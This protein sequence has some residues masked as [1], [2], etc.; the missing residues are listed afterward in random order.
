MRMVFERGTVGFRLLTLSAGMVALTG[1]TTSCGGDGEAS[2]GGGTE[3]VVGA[4]TPLS[5]DYAAVSA[6]VKA[7]EAAFKE[8]NANGGIDGVKVKFIM[9]DDQYNPANTPSATRDLVESEGAVMM[10]DSQGAVP[11]ASVKDYLES[12]QIPTVVNAGD[13]TLDGEFHYLVISDYQK[14]GAELVRYASEDLGAKSIAVTYSDDALGNPV[15]EG[16]EAELSN[17][18]LDSAATIKFDP[19]A[20]SMS[21]QAAQLKESGADFVVLPGTA[22]TVAKLINSAEQI[23]YT[24]DWGLMFA[25]QSPV[26]D[27]LTK[28][29]VDG[30]AH[31]VTPFIDPASDAGAEYRETL[32]E[33]APDIEPNDGPTIAG[34]TIAKVCIAA[35]EKAVEAANG[36]V[37]TSEQIQDALSS[38]TLDD[39]FIQGIDW[40]GDTHQ[41][42]SSGQVLKL[43]GGEF[44][45]QTDFAPFPEVG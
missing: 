38:L 17:L 24:P 30:R 42:S 33:Y 9:R 43:E 3:I 35:L 23:G 31:F 14:F 8:L 21:A 13:P 4:T 2:S 12:R 39:E 36:E 1:L 11:Q 37:P 26:L 10:C 27:E 32:E 22:P 40:S 6:G 19:A 5:G 16:A 45:P 41:G 44:V 25:A 18:S 20:S 28:G 7:G 29:K 34:Y 15:R